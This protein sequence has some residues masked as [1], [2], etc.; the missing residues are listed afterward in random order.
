MD[1]LTYICI[2]FSLKCSQCQEVPGYHIVF[3]NENQHFFF[4]LLVKNAYYYIQ[5]ERLGFAV[6]NMMPFGTCLDGISIY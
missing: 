2:R 6:R 3:Y 4:N 1:Q 5:R